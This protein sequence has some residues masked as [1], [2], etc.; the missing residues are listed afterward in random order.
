MLERCR[1]ESG[2]YVA[3]NCHAFRLVF[4]GL[5]TRSYEM[6]AESEEARHDWMKVRPARG[7]LLVLTVAGAR[8]RPRQAIT[9]ASYEYLRLAVGDLQRRILELETAAREEATS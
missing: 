4:D 2:N 5:N 9:E 7:G 8:G 3:P 1:V 6:A